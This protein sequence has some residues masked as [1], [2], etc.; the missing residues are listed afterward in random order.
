MIKT[1]VFRIT[2]IC[3]ACCII[4]S[5]EF[6]LRIAKPDLARSIECFRMNTERND[7]RCFSAIKKQDP[8]LLWKLRPN[9]P[10][11]ENERLNSHGFRGPEFSIVKPPDTYRVLILGDSRSFGFGL[12]NY[13]DIYSARIQHYFDQT[14]GQ[15]KTEILNLSV[16]G[17]SSYQGKVLLKKFGNILKPDMVIIWFGF[18]DLLYYFVSDQAAASQPQIQK[19]MYRFLNRSYLYQWLSQ[20]WSKRL[21]PT[22]RNLEFDEPITERVPPDNYRQNLSEMILYI[23]QMGARALLLSTPVRDAPPLVLNSL[24]RKT[25][26]DSGKLLISSVVQ[27][28]IDGYWLM[29]KL[30]FPGTEDEL[31][32]LMEKNPDMAILHYFKALKLLEK[33]EFDAAQSAFRVAEKLD[34]TRKV[35]AEYNEIAQKVADEKHV[36]FIDLA[37]TFEKFSNYPLFLDDCHPNINGHNLIAA[38]IIETLTGIPSRQQNSYAIVED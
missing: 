14:F 30:E 5:I 15:G 18:N 24:I 33:G 32:R 13:E 3:L 36:I 35:V 23:Q 31:D 2:S 29:D 6:V 16:I 27:Y 21:N 34:Y 20:I 8:D 1:W 17:Y 10:L 26:S 19:C 4:L 37:S 11:S 25:P 12:V 22:S 9:S 7:A 38:R 28:D